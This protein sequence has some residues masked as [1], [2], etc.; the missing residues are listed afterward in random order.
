MNRPDYYNFHKE[1][2]GIFSE[3]NP[4]DIPDYYSD[5]STEVGKVRSGAG[6]ID[7][8]DRGKLKLSGKE[9]LKLLQGML[10]NDVLKLENF[11][12]L[13]ATSLTV[14]GKII[15][16]MRVHKFDDNILLDLEPGINE[17]YGPF[18]LKY[19]LSYK[20]DIEDITES[21][22]LIHLCGPDS[23]G[24]IKK[25]FN[26]DKVPV[27]EFDSLVLNKDGGDILII[28]INRTGETGYDLY[29][30]NETG[31]RV[32]SDLINSNADDGLTPFGLKT[33]DTLRIEAGIPVLGKDMD[34]NT[35]PIEAGLWNA[36]DFEK[37]CY[38]G[39]EVVARI[40]WRGRVNWHLVGFEIDEINDALKSGSEIFSGDKKI[41]RVTS[42]VHS[43]TLDKAIAI[44]YIRREFNENGVNV[45]IK[46]S[47]NLHL[48]AA[49]SALPFVNSFK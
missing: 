23:T 25:N 42:F 32:W 15:T 2:G 22:S 29:A 24:I 18:L 12:G 37:G 38:I 20:A 17:T 14:K 11:R 13:Y 41:G 43:P 21:H 35:I 1:H 19:R 33:L 3:E 26:L 28:K 49:V 40:K 47:K 48:K 44:G 8:S 27:N 7:L 6:I 9:H 31:F 39:Q 10:T 36:L 5:I 30:D 46:L 45:E 16:D 34:E 4:G